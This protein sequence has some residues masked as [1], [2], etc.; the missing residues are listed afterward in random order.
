MI[1]AL[2]QIVNDGFARQREITERYY[3]GELTEREAKEQGA[4]SHE[5]DKVLV[6]EL[7]GEEGAED[8]GLIV[9]EEGAKMKAEKMMGDQ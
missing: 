3:A 5:D 1:D 6:T 7:L 9:Q 2:Q 4:Q 8:F